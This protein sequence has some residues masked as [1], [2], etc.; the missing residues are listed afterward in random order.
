MNLRECIA[1]RLLALHQH[2]DSEKLQSIAIARVAKDP[3]LFFDEWVWTYDPRLTKTPYIPMV[4]FPIQGEYIEWLLER[5][6]N[7]ED[8]VVEKSRD[9]GMTWLSA[10][11]LIH[12]WLFV[13]GFKGSIGSRKAMLVDRIGDPDSIF[14]KMRMILRQLP[15]WMMPVGFNPNLHDCGAKLINPESGATLTGEGGDNIGR[16][17]R[18]SMYFV[19][20]AAFLERAQKIDAALSANTD[21]RIYGSTPNGM[22]NLFYQK[23]FSGSV[24]VFTM[25]WK[26][27]SRKNY[28]FAQNADGETIAE[29]R[30][31]A[32]DAPVGAKVVY[33]WYENQKTRLADPVI[34]AQEVDIDYTASL[35]D[36]AIPARWVIAAVN[37]VRPAKRLPTSRDI[38]AALDVAD[39]GGCINVLTIRF[40]PVVTHVFTREEGNTTDT[41]NWAVDLCRKHGVRILYYDSVGVGAGISGALRSKARTEPLGFT[42]VA[43]NVGASPS[44][45]AWPTGKT[46]KEM[47]FNLKA[48]IWWTT[49][50][51]FEK[52]YEVVNG[53]AEHPESDL[54][55]LVND[56][57]VIREL[58]NVRRFYTENGKIKIETK[59]QLDKRGVK[60]PD[61][62]DSF[63]MLF[64]PIGIGRAPAAGGERTTVTAAR[65][66]IGGNNGR[67]DIANQYR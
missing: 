3:C 44:D 50:A 11:F 29:G 65:R 45:A 14:E 12:H 4:L 43:V 2:N 30:G 49:R 28:W 36:I 17:G 23:R 61:F 39:G 32:L 34:L 59:A 19:D 33:P 54:I 1:K 53:I 7:K 63:V 21:C 20:E 38:V 31:E 51:R 35:P 55:S 15:A 40:G 67:Q 58:S 46:S 56:P 18:S 5:E 16:G 9:M 27:D 10:G 52:T 8:G 41:A 57:R 47:F 24:S 6:R 66:A 26:R 22:G 62:A 64:A 25:H 48:E 42:A 60:S 13:P 37:R